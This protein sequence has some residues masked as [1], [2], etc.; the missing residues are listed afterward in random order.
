MRLSLLVLIILSCAARA[1]DW[2]K[3]YDGYPE[4]PLESQPK[5]SVVS[6]DQNS[7]TIRVE[8]STKGNLAYQQYDESDTPS[9]YWEEMI[10]GKWQGTDWPWCGTGLGSR[11]IPPGSHLDLVIPLKEKQNP[12]KVYIRLF[13]GE[14]RKASF[15][16]LYKSK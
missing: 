4:A 16:L 2:R 12:L 10:S 3:M 8:N 1:Q 13:D 7:A 5:V 9:L 6:A 15:V 14:A 11:V